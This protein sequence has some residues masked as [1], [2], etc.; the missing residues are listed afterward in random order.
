MDQGMLEVSEKKYCSKLNSLIEE[1]N[2]V[3]AM[4]ATLKNDIKVV[5]Y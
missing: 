5:I 2:D 4:L 3:D 1:T